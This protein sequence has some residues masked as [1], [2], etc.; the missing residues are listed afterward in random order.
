MGALNG[1]R[2]LTLSGFP[3]NCI[4]TLQIGLFVT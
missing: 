3:K 1:N 4:L 2:R